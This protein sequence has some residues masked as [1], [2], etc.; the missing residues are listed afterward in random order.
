MLRV[1]PLLRS[2]RSFRASR[3]VKSA[4]RALGVAVLLCIASRSSA[5][6]IAAVP[7]DTVSIVNRA[8][9]SYSDSALATGADSATATV[10]LH[11]TAGLTFAPPRAQAAPPGIRRALAHL[12]RNTGTAYDVY[13]LAASAPAGWT[14]TVYRDVDADGQLGAGDVA[15]GASVALAR[16]DSVALL[17][18]AD[19]PA[20][21]AG[22]FVGALDLRATSTMDPTVSASVADRLTIVAGA[23]ASGIA[24]DKA[25]DRAAA[26]AG[27]TL[28]YSLSFINAG[29]APTAAATVTD[30]LPAGLRYVPGSLRYDA[31]A[32]SDAPDSDAGQIA[33]DGS[34]VE[35]V[36][37]A[38]GAIAPSAGG[39]I[40]FRAVVTAD[41]VQGTIANVAS[42][43]AGAPLATSQAA[44]TAVSAADLQVT[45]S[46]VGA[47]SVA[48]GDLVT[49]RITVTNRSTTVAALGVALADTLPAGLEFVSAEGAPSVAG[50]VVTW[51]IGTLDDSPQ[52]FLLVA[53]A[54]RPSAPAGLVNG[55]VVTSTN[56][57]AAAGAAAALRIA[58]YSGAELGLAM[59]AGVLEAGLG[60]PVPYSLVVRNR[61]SV[62]L[63]DV[64]VRSVLPAGMG[65]VTK[66]LAGADSARASGQIV[67][68]YLH[69]TLAVGEERVV[70]YGAVL[71]ASGKARSVVN[72]A[73]ALGA[74]GVI[75][76]DTASASVRVRA[77]FA[78]QGRTLLGKVYLDRDGDGV[79]S[80]G[81]E[82]VAGAQL[83][84][85]DGQIVVTDKEGRFSLR[86]VAPGTHAVRLDT[87]V[88][89]PAGF[90]LA[91]AADEIVVVRTDGWTTPR[92]EFR[93]VKR[94]GA[95]A[96]PDT[97]AL[98]VQAGAV[99]APVEPPAPRIAALRTAADRDADERGSFLSGPT[100]RIASPADGAIVGTNKV[101][102]GVKGE[103]G[104]AVTL[105]EGDRV[106]GEAALRPDGS[107]DFIGV[108]L[109]PGTHRLRVKMLNSWHNERWDSLAVHRSGEPAA[110]ELAPEDT[111]TLDLHADAETAVSMRAR[112]LDKWRVPVATR[113]D[114]TVAVTNVV[115]EGADSDAGSVG[116]QRRADAN[117][118]VTLGLRAGHEVGEGKVTLR[119]GEKL[120][121]RRALRVLPTLHRF[122]ATGAGQVG[123]G[124]AGRSFGAVAARGSIGAGT[125]LTLSY[126]SRR[127]GENDFFG[128]GYDPLDE[129]RYATYG[130]GSERRVLSGSTQ[131]FSARFER[132]LDWM[133]LGDVVA[134]PAA[135]QDALLAGYQ[136]S[137]SGVAARVTTGALTWRGFGSMTRQALQ[138]IQLRGD[139]GTGPYVFGAGGRPGTDRIT[140]EIRARDNAA[141]I[142]AREELQRFSDYEIDY[143]TG[144]VLMRRPVPT[145]DSYGN[146]VFVVAALERESGGSEHFVG[147]GR[148]EANLSRWLPPRGVDSLLLGVTAVRDG[149]AA[150]STTASG[151]AMDVRG[152]DLRVR[153]R[154]LTLGGELL[155]TI[156]PDSSGSAARASARYALADGRAS[157]GASWTRVSDGMSGSLDPR[158]G[159][160]VTQLHADATLKLAAE[161]QVALAHDRQQF[162]QYGVE[163]RTT[164]ARANAMVGGRKVTQELGL[165][166]DAQGA[167]GGLASATTLTSKTTVSVASRADVWVEGSHALT[168]PAVAPAVATPD[169][170]TAAAAI[171]PG[172]VVTQRPDQVGVGV[173]YRLTQG[174]R[175]EA[176]HRMSLVADS[177][178][179]QRHYSVTSLNLRTQKLFGGEAWGGVERAGASRASH[180]AVLG[181]NQRLAVGGGWSL[182]SLYERRVGLSKASLLDPVRALP[183]VR[184]E[185][186][187][188]SVGGG[189]E[190]LPKNDHSRFS[191]HGESRDGDG[192]R[193]QRF[194]LAADAPLGADAALI[195]LHDWSRYTVTAGTLASQT[196]RQ[197]RSLVGMALRP[198]RS[199]ALDMLAKLEW[200]RTLNPLAGAAG[201]SSV[202]GATGEDRRL[203]GATDVIWS[204][205]RRTEIAARYAVRW[206]QNSQLTTAEGTPIGVSAQYLGASGEQAIAR[207]GALR[208]RLD[209]R[210]MLEQAS[211][212]RPWNAAPSV[213]LRVGPSIEVESGYRFGAL[214]DLDF[215]A[216]GGAGLFVTVGVRFT[217]RL[218]ASPA[219]FWRDRL[220]SGR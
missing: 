156:T 138:Q 34:G 206:S 181:W 60:E 139:G 184:P 194:T 159:A 99:H 30:V 69:G 120:V 93:L 140:I 90:G 45:K 19:I 218:L 211:G 27:D 188:W 65:F 41:A 205:T 109:A 104:A 56:A 47:D 17:L 142:I 102:V 48:A 96:L 121:A 114:V 63:F 146:P 150:A 119:S 210:M 67:D 200:R 189:V 5:Q 24:L 77:G 15:A 78:M 124:A 175:L 213:V 75:R 164:T 187:R 171:L 108:E 57:R 36:G 168:P 61:G 157:V 161:S 153:L 172:G 20:G 87:L 152:A 113:P 53:R 191:L 8:L 80:A 58:G 55:A 143:A 212:A 202:L 4:W 148:V 158:L 23:S 125:S 33:R 192:R 127:G 21:A 177:A 52:S 68:V 107:Q 46:L 106:I 1:L 126:D 131:R 216:D 110:L 117:G 98:V 151:A 6:S 42:I 201:S 183:F 14:V 49:Y 94:A 9:L 25:V 198:V 88:G 219:A 86:D 22:G 190:W 66:S 37:V 134:R 62:P 155:H 28:T 100:V 204:A 135:D 111:A 101:Y 128:R 84:T 199:T 170:N 160:G 82:G 76:S 176:V 141:R 39:S 203:L 29:T 115:L 154:A 214:Q 72:R 132:G 71:A 26:V 207:D 162:A 112:V 166:T 195:T 163:R 11:L 103:A 31:A 85:A 145:E 122:I 133:E 89:I 44:A 137:L 178:M 217:E 173:S 74:G 167:A 97:S 38:V 105:Y 208:L 83:V 186:D 18:V 209:T 3:Q 149:G 50:Q 81:E 70:R 10:L 130:D 179:E 169:T 92:T 2:S 79:Q 13:T 16:D 197:D 7:T 43:A 95:A 129:A 144:A 12:L 174:L 220:A 165:A 116:E 147:G 51:T 73:V 193:G 54:V 180:S 64:A 196:S 215:A 35:T 123:A 118:W 91:R 136:R 185:G 59:S 40:S 182:S 32:L